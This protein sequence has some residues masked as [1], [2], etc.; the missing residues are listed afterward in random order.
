M[1]RKKRQRRRRKREEKGK[2]EGERKGEKDM[3]RRGA[4]GKAEALATMPDDQSLSSVT[5]NSHKLPPDLH[6]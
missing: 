5:H 3:V 2:R 6:T 4:M 1:R